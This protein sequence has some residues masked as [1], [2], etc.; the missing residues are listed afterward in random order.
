VSKNI[1]FFVNLTL[2]YFIILV[3]AGLATLP[4]DK[5]FIYLYGVYAH[6][7]MDLVPFV[8]NVHPDTEKKYSKEIRKSIQSWNK[9]FDKEF[10]VIGK[11][12]EKYDSQKENGTVF[13]TVEDLSK[14]KDPVAG[15]TAFFLN[16]RFRIRTAKITMHSAQSTDF[17]QV[18]THELGHVLG[19]ADDK[20]PG[21]LMHYQAQ[22]RTAHITEKDMELI[23]DLL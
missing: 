20:Y 12:T 1:K 11:I 15:F 23:R 6:I 8:V 10:F 17:G 9:L 16:K 18:L 22:H 2:A 4:G 5:G 14:Y 21:S 3:C 7:D 19:L 13:I